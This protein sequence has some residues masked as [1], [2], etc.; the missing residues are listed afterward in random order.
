MLKNSYSIFSKVF[1]FSW[2]KNQGRLGKPRSSSSL[3]FSKI[4]FTF[5]SITASYVNHTLVHLYFCLSVF[6]YSFSAVRLSLAGPESFPWESLAWEQLCLKGSAST[7]IR[8]SYL[9]AGTGELNYCTYDDNKLI[10]SK[11]FVKT[12]PRWIKINR[13]YVISFFNSCLPNTFT[14]KHTVPL[15]PCSNS[16]FSIYSVNKF[17]DESSSFKFIFSEST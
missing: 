17:C 4:I 10:F 14:Y 11:T 12:V 5:L 7:S 13:T 9:E 8:E 3:G 16:H 15:L 6:L 1:N 2:Y